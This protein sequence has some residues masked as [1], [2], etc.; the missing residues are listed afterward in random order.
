MNTTRRRFMQGTVAASAGMAFGQSSSIPKRPLGKTGLQV[1][2]L[3]V[4]GYHLGTAERKRFPHRLFTRRSITALIFSI[5]RGNTTRE[6][7]RN[8]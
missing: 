2:A 6:S 5:A 4:G 3:G 7:V 1:S 8:G